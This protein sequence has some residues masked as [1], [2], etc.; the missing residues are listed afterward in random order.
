MT[1]HFRFYTGILGHKNS[2]SWLFGGGKEFDHEF[3]M[4][5]K[6][7][8]GTVEAAPQLA[9]QLYIVIRSGLDWTAW[10]SRININVSFN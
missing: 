2:P 9:L 5:C 10:K 3:A 6:C 8:E 1:H 4:A 7:V